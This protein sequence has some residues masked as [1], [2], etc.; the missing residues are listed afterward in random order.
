MI[1]FK[2]VVKKYDNNITATN[3]ISVKI[4]PGEFVYVVGPSGA[5]KSTFIKMMYR[6][7]APTSGSIIVNEYALE[8]IKSREIPFLRRELG[9][10]FQD[11]KLLPRLTVFENI[12]YALQVIEKTPEEVEQRVSRV[13]DLVGLS[14][15][16]DNFP[17]ELSGGEQQ[18]VAIARAIANEP[19]ILIADEP[20]GNLDPET[21][22]GIMEILEQV[23]KQGTTVVMAT[24]NSFIVN[25]YKHRVLEINGGKIIRDEEEGVYSNE[26]ANA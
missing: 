7:E 1:E 10:V 14:A 20:T 15:K 23:N 19:S 8:N 24:H 6:E 16:R 25:E 4:K 2:N 12:A 22:E 21:A 5:G 13:L 3:N 17:A 9:I 18:R 26:D 11:F